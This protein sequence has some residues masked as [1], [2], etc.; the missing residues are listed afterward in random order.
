MPFL[1]IEIM[2]MLISLSLEPHQKITNI[3]VFNIEYQ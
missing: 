2:A 3:S 1:R